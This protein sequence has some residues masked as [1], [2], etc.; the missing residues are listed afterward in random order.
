VIADEIA[1][2]RDETSASPDVEVVR[3]VMPSLLR[4]NG[5]LVAISTPYRKLGLLYQKWRDNFGV[6]SDDVLVIQGGT[7]QFNP[8]ISA[9]DI[10]KASADDPER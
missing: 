10:A 4:T 5:S 2:W 6:S 3:A 8:T 1:Y 7:A 9:A